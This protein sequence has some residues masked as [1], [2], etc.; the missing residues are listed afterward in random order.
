VFDTDITLIEGTS[1]SQNDLLKL[2]LKIRTELKEERKLSEQDQLR[3]RILDEQLKNGEPFWCPEETI[4]QMTFEKK[5]AISQDKI[6]EVRRSL[7]EQFKHFEKVGEELEVHAVYLKQK[8]NLHWGIMTKTQMYHL[9]LLEGEE[10]HFVCSK[11]QD[12]QDI[13][14]LDSHLVGRTNFSNFGLLI[15]GETLIRT[16]G[17]HYHTFWNCQ[18][19]VNCF[20][21]IICVGN[22]SK[23]ATSSE[24]LRMLMFGPLLEPIHPNVTNEWERPLF[25]V[26]KQE[27]IHTMKRWKLLNTEEDLE[28]KKILSKKS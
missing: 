22:H 3:K 21:D 5:Y 4:S 13:E 15:I 20:L 26:I 9:A 24:V 2:G 8:S 14:F 6:A 16:F 25:Y 23:I 18:D 27:P 10:L 12:L 7:K 19:F 17:T 28:I 11:M 1:F